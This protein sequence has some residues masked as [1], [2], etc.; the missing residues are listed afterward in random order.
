MIIALVSILLDIATVKTSY[1]GTPTQPERRSALKCLCTVKLLPIELVRIAIVIVGLILLITVDRYCDCVNAA[2]RIG[3]ESGFG[4]GRFM[5]SCRRFSLWFGCLI[6]IVVTQLFEVGFD[7]MV[8]IH[9]IYKVTRQKYSSKR[10][11]DGTND[12]EGAEKKWE[13]CCVK[14][15]QCTSL[16]TCCLFGGYRNN[17]SD[18]SSVA[19]ALADFMADK[20]TVDCV[21]SDVVAG[22][23]MLLKVQK[24][25]KI[26]SREAL[27][28]AKIDEGVPSAAAKT[29]KS[30][31]RSKLGMKK[32]VN[33]K[34]KGEG[35]ITLDGQNEKSAYDG[36]EPCVINAQ[37]PLYEEEELEDNLSSSEHLPLVKEKSEGCEDWTMSNIEEGLDGPAHKLSEKKTSSGVGESTLQSSRQSMLKMMKD[38]ALLEEKRY[39]GYSADND[40]SIADSGHALTYR[41]KREGDKVTTVPAIRKILSPAVAVDRSALAEGA[42][43][44]RVALAIYTWMMFIFNRPCLGAGLLGCARSMTFLRRVRQSKKDST[45]IGDNICGCN[46]AALFVQ[47]GINETD[48]VYAQ[49]S[50]IGCKLPYCILID[51]EWKSVVVAIRG[52]LSLD[53][54]IRDITID[55]HPLEKVCEKYGF[56]GQ[57]ESAHYGMYESAE[58]IYDDI[59]SHGVLEKLLLAESAECAGFKL[60]VVG[61]S[62]GAGVAAIL[63]LMLRRKYPDLKGL[64]FSP[65]GCV[66][67]RKTA[68]ECKEFITSY[69]LN[70]DLVP[71]LCLKSLENLRNEV[72]LLINRIKIPKHYVVT[73]AFFSTIGNI[74]VAKE[75]SGEVL[76][77]LNSI[78]SSEFGKQLNDFKKAQ[79]TRKEK[80]GIFQVQMF[81]P[82]DVVYLHKTS[83]DRNCLHGLLSCTTCGVVQKQ[84]IY[85]ARWAQYDDF[86]EILIGQ[87]MLTDHF[88]QNVCHELERIAASFGI[89]FPYND[90]SGN[91]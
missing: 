73:P 25:R 63:A 72:L 86:Q 17:A 24:E 77:G 69:A 26:K 66:F 22:M 6:C 51:R 52:T 37:S 70:T 74:N 19:I 53:D 76:H 68:D 16:L 90:Y 82:G 49:F 87:S 67:S 45:I 75:S 31:M 54:L 61:H 29:T 46:E 40:S 57:G 71:R 13:N 84:P 4:D 85:S 78:P 58:W 28:K 1:T 12:N 89:D 21:F 83:D 36:G 48:I 30:I 3:E 88:P 34:K 23:V 35:L 41:I 11:I 20:G 50:N 18:F 38:A 5:N 81:P 59:Q 43:Y 64:C 27:I 32:T 42:R 33:P 56:D 8:V 44:S 7:A 80:R 2:G 60:R 91:G 15:C 79:E 39:L 47:A 62:L 10:D 55:P 9:G 65:P 14:C